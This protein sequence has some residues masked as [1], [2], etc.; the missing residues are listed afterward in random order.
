MIGLQIEYSHHVPVETLR[1]D[2]APG[3]DV[4][5]LSGDPDAKAWVTKCETR[6]TGDDSKPAGFPEAVATEIALE[7]SD[8]LLALSH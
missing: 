8:C 7:S 4:D 5:R 1:P 6:V 3:F 2:T